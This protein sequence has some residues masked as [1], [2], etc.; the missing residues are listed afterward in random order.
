MLVS[1]RKGF[2]SEK[3][4]SFYLYCIFFMRVEIK[5]CWCVEILLKNPAE[6]CNTPPESLRVFFSPCNVIWPHLGRRK[7]LRKRG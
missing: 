7:Q 1:G 6:D 3:T 5:V 4:F 2:Q